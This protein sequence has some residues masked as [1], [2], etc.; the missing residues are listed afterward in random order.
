MYPNASLTTDEHLYN[1]EFGQK[2]SVFNLWMSYDIAWT[3]HLIL[4]KSIFLF[5]LF[6]I[7]Y[8][9]ITNN[10]PI[11]PITIYV[12]YIIS[13]LAHMDHDNKHVSVNK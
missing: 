4:T 10:F 9:Q 1:V 13:L 5:A 7:I 3:F 6:M 8:L 2:T 12:N 11:S